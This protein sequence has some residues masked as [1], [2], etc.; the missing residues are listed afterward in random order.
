MTPAKVAGQF[1][2]TTYTKVFVGGLAWETQKD[3]MRKYF[4]QFGEILEAVVITDKITGRSKG[5]GF[6]TFRDPDAAMRACV[7][8]APVID[9]RRAN[10]NLASLGVQRS[11]PSTPKHGGGRNIRVIGGGLHQ[12]GFQAAA[13][14]AAAFASAAA[15]PHYSIQ[16]G[17]PYNLYGYPPYSTEYAFPA[18]YYGV[19]G[20]GC[21][22]YPL[23]GCGSSSSGGYFS[24]V[25]L[26]EG[27]NSTGYTGSHQQ[28]QQQQQGYGVQYPNHGL[29]HYSPITS[30]PIYSPHYAGAATP[31]S[32]APS[33]P[34]QPAVC[35]AVTQA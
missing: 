4:E 8:A 19:Y 17:I 13:A 1:G 29:F 9:G 22:P 21:A 18:S 10:C 12:G 34:L 27:T 33:T 6:V 25:N 31:L 11:K 26:N 28:Q 15:F 16:Q 2:D 30:A 5:Y 20:G 35:F 24:Y 23:Y 32:L 14:A 7:D 3:T